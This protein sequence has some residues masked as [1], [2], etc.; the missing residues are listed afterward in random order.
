MSA[1]DNT[2]LT[3]S[4]THPIL[5]TEW[6]NDKNA[7]LTPENV[8]AGSDRLVWWKCPKGH[9]YDARICFR[10]RGTGCPICL[11]RRILVGFNDLATTHPEIAAEW[12]YSKNGNLTPQDVCIGGRTKVWW[13]CKNG[14]EWESPIYSRRKNGCRYC[15]G[16]Y[17]DSL[18]VTHPDVAKDWHPTKNGDLTPRDVTAGSK[19]TVW[20]LGECGHDWSSQVKTKVAGHGCPYCTNRRLLVGFND[21]ETVNP[22]VAKE[23]HPSKNAP[24][25]PKDVIAYS[26]QK[27]WWQCSEGHEWKSQVVVRQNGHGCRYCNSHRLL[28]GFNDLATV[29][30]ELIKEW[31]PTKNG[32]LTPRD[33]T[34]STSKRVWWIC[35]KGHE[36]EAS[37]YDRTLGS[38]CPQCGGFSTSLPEQGIAYYLETVCKVE[39]RIKIDMKEIDV[40]LPEYK[41]GIEYD[42]VYFHAGKE[43]KEKLKDKSTMNRGI[44]LIRIKEGEENEIVN[45]DVIKFATD[46]MGANYEWALKQLFNILYTLTDNAAFI[47]IP[48]D[49][50]KDRLKIRE[51]LSLYIKKNS[52]SAK[53]PELAKQ[54]HPTKNGI[55]TPEMFSAG[56]SETV[57]WLCEKGHEWD[58]PISARNSGNGCP[59]CFGASRSKRVVE[60]IL[61][62]GGSLQAKYPEIAKEWHPTKNGELTPK[63]VTARSTKNYWWLCEK[64]HEWDDTVNYRVNGHGCPICSKSNNHKRRIEQ[65]LSQGGSLQARYPEIAKE[66]HP[67]KN[68]KLTPK[69]VTAS[70][71]NK[72]WWLCQNGH[73]WFANINNRTQ[74]HGCPKCSKRIGINKRFKQQALDGG[75]LQ[76]KNPELAEEWHPTK[77]GKL[78]PCEVT[79][80][81]KK[82]VWWLGKCGHEWPAVV[83]NRVN[84][85][86]CPVCSKW[87]VKKVLCI[88]TGIIYDNCVEAKKATGASKVG[89]CCRGRRKKSGGYHWRYVD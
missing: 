19:K 54:W 22:E 13:L 39:Q 43:E 73:E 62:Q 40:Y 36:W 63:D 20:W 42:G 79:Y 38:R 21:L 81:S 11:N 58:A 16:R 26:N 34:P 65:I 7:P 45:G 33:V 27:V 84:G 68:G 2:K 74:G 6:D 10:A 9:E 64:G 41:I 1:K 17:S 82:T 15:S 88:E 44:L 69:D 77:N 4:V 75:S 47:T 78:L 51:R 55:L 23:W 30:P 57:W 32:K 53:N 52:L 56:S 25:K 61:S 31:H 3:L 49:V 8:T 37:V 80:K 76:D 66:W 35:V 24:L 48:I 18:Q 86:G 28:V 59:I 46:H 5:A 72:Y 70:T 29:N 14:H 12:N 60:Q 50:K 87:S 85:T 89:E 71:S 67:T 83:G